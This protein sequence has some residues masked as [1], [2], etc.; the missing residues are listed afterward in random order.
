MSLLVFACDVLAAY[1]SALLYARRWLLRASRAQVSL[2]ASGVPPHAIMIA[3]SLT[4]DQSTVRVNPSILAS[5][6]LR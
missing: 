2:C 4:D 5:H 3:V 6:A 1:F